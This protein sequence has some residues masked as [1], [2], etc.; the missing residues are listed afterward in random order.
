MAKTCGTYVTWRHC[1]CPEDASFG[2]F[3]YLTRFTTLAVIQKILVA[4]ADGICEGKPFAEIKTDM[5]QTALTQLPA[6]HNASLQRMS[7]NFAK[8]LESFKSSEQHLVQK[9]RGP[10]TKLLDGPFKKLKTVAENEKKSGKSC[11]DARPAILMAGCKLIN[12][13][14]ILDVFKVCKKKMTGDEWK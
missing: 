13:M 7:N 1:Q 4:A 10:L 3:Q 8:C 2:I 6:S 14:L 5:V 11:E 12:Y 9:L